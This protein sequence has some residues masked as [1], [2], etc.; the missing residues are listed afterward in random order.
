MN[1]SSKIMTISSIILVGF[2][3]GVI[4][5][6]ILG[7]YLNGVYPFNTFLGSP[8]EAFNDFTGL[9]IIIKDFAPFKV[10]NP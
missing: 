3:L 8:S 7:F 5:H 1:K 6:Y 4:F 9:L 10:T 2:L